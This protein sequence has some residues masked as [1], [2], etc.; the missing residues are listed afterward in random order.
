[1]NTHA[2][3]PTDF[4]IHK[5]PMI[6]MGSVVSITL[7]L[8]IS[9]SFG[10]FDRQG[11]PET[12]RAENGVQSVDTRSIQFNDD[13]DGSVWVSDAVTGAELARFPQGEGGFVRATARAMIHNRERH[14]F[15]P[16]VPFELIK[17]NDG[18]LTLRDAQTARAV[19]LA[20]FG[21]QTHTV[22]KEILVK[23]RE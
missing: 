12:V 17:W 2:V 4:R 15:G 20:S 1:M 14:G 9:T 23:G 7:A 21:S 16:A 19:E 8:A 3:K 18:T 22:Y 11:V 10:V 6:A 13:T 5:L